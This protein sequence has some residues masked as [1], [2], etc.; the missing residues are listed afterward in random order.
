MKKEI[1]EFRYDSWNEHNK[2]NMQSAFTKLFTLR[3]TL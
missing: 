1:I 3:I 2:D